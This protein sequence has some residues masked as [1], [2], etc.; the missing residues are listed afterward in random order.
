[1]KNSFNA[2]CI[3]VEKDDDGE[4]STCASFS[5][6]KADLNEYYERINCRCID[7]AGIKID[8]KY[9]DVICDDEGLLKDGD[10]YCTIAT[11]SG[12][13]LIVGNVIICHHNDEG[14]ETSITRAEA[15]NIL[16]NHTAF[17]I[18]NDH[19]ILVIIAD[20]PDW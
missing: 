2:L 13:V 7:I 15:F 4:V 10:I 11:P 18:Q 3:S 19:G 17:S 5:R 20:E 8:G 14:E 9:Y 16:C 1:M 6:V 12:R